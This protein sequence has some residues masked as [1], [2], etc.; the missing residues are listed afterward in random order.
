[1]NSLTPVQVI[2]GLTLKRDDLY[3]PFG[4][5]GVNGGKLRQCMMLLNNLNGKYESVLSY[6]SLHSPQAPITA[7]AAK[8]HGMD[9][10][11]L[12]GGTNADRIKQMPMPRLAAQYGAR[13]VVAAKSGRHTVLH[14]K[15][16]IMAK[17]SS[18]FIVQYGINLTEH[19]EVLF[20]AV[21]AQVENIPDE[22]PNLVLTCGSGITATGVLLGIHFF[23]KQIQQIHLIGT[24]P[25]RERFIHSQLSA[26][27]ADRKICYHDLFNS[28]GFV[29]EK[30]V[31]QNWGG[32]QLHP[33]YE[34]KAMQ[35]FKASKLKP[36]ETLFWIVGAEPSTRG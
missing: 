10:T 35:W 15:A 11:I 3:A 22:I 7:A 17:E 12:Y 2:N 9:C 30:P 36:E 19:A 29:Y 31:H 1:M 5:T 21:A 8:A 16:K 32:L 13:I 28:A 33:Q 24:A 6:C 26:A 34:A 4:E 27:G 25:N 20:Q 14:S 23:G 18:S